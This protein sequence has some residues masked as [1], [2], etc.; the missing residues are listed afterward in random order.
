MRSHLESLKPVLEENTIR[1]DED[2]Y[3]YPLGL[4]TDSPLSQKIFGDPV[5]SAFN[6]EEL[7]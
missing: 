5:P 4:K 3:V 6:A 1:L 7:E 2:V